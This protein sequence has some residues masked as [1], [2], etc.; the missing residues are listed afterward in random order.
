MAIAKAKLGNYPEGL[1][2]IDFII[3]IQED[4]EGKVSAAVNCSEEIRSSIMLESQI[5]SSAQYDS[6]RQR[7][8]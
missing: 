3:K 8:E 5:H 1:S 4:C 2:L 6:E 7:P